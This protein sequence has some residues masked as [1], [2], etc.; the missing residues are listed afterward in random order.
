MLLLTG[1]QNTS[2]SNEYIDYKVDSKN[3]IEKGPKKNRWSA[4]ESCNTLFITKEVVI[5]YRVNIE[6]R[7]INE[8]WDER[9]TRKRSND[10]VNLLKKMFPIH[11]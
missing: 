3:T 8:L 4:Y 2:Q 10:L 1:P 6:S 7:K 9:D 5:T 11:L